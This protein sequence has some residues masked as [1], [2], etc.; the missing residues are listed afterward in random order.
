MAE[1]R[2]YTLRLNSLDES[3]LNDA[4]EIIKDGLCID[5][6]DAIIIKSALQFYVKSLKSNPDLVKM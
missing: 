6:T 2:T 3:F 4:R 5:V 1:S